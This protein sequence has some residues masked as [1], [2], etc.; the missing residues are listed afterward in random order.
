MAQIPVMVSNLPEMR[1]VVSSSQV[2][3]VMEDWSREAFLNTLSKL[4]SMDRDYLKNQ[5]TKTSQEF[6]WEEQEKVMLAAYQQ[7]II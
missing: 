5:L 3:V 6:C 7:Y 1:E 4:V 2:G